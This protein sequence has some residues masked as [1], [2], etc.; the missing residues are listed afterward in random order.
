MGDPQQFTGR[1]ERATNAHDLEPLVACF[2]EDYV[3]E[4]PV[5]PARGFVGR[6]QVR[7][8]W[9]QI[10]A[11]VPDVHARV[12]R[13]AE[14]GETRWTEREMTGTRADGSA[15]CMRGVIL[16]GIRDGLISS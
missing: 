7:S 16:F 4:T 6:A 9:E 12:L 11:L 1:L 8:N 3:N 5:H 10:F 2:A 13:E 14:G 15:H